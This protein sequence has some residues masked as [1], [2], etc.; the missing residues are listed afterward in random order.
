[1]P[2]DFLIWRRMAILANL[3]ESLSQQ[4]LAD[5]PQE[6]D[7]AADWPRFRWHQLASHVYLS[8]ELEIQSLVPQYL[9]CIFSMSHMQKSI[10]ESVHEMTITA[11][12]RSSCSFGNVAVAAAGLRASVPPVWDCALPQLHRSEDIHSQNHLQRSGCPPA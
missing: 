7:D 1:M 10:T 9:F 6:K 3:A 8:T 2:E 11:T 5:H 4:C 12:G